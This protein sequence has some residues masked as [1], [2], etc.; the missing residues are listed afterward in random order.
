MRKGTKRRIR[1]T[2][3][4][5]IPFMVER[6]F[7][8]HKEEMMSLRV[9]HLIE[10]IFAGIDGDLND[11]MKYS[12][13]WSEEDKKYLYTYIDTLEKKLIQCKEKL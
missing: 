7:P 5:R 1:L 8:E 3:P 9:R 2:P 12:E 6:D 11:L 10:Y 13:G 4:S